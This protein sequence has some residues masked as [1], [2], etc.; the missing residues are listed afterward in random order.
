MNNNGM[1]PIKLTT[2][3]SDAGLYVYNPDVV[4]NYIEAQ[5]LLFN[6]KVPKTTFS[7][8]FTFVPGETVLKSIKLTG[9]KSKV[10]NGWE[11]IEPDKFPNLQ[12]TLGSEYRLDKLE[13]PDLYKEILK[14]ELMPDRDIE[15]TSEEGGFVTVPKDYN[16]PV[17]TYKSKD[18]TIPVVAHWDLIT[19]AIIPEISLENQPCYIPSSKWYAVIRSHIKENIDSRVAEITSDFDFCFTVQKKIKL[20]TPK[21]FQTEITKSTRKN[22]RPPVFVTKVKEYN[23]LK[24]FEMTHDGENYNGYTPIPAIKGDNLSELRENVNKFLTDL[25]ERINKPVEYCQHCEGSGIII[26]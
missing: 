24:C 22:Y 2:F 21:I 14:E 7:E 18:K 17:A 6:G 26:K 11:L 5:R 23:L 4:Y 25:M 20:N 16:T 15:F 10:F 13:Y 9:V 8:K 12:K 3:Q 19:R 1:T